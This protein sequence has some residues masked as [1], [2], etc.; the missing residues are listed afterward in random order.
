MGNRANLY[1]YVLIQVN[2]YMLQIVYDEVKHCQEEVWRGRNFKV[3][4]HQESAKISGRCKKIIFKRVQDFYIF[5]KNCSHVCSLCLF[6][7]TWFQLNHFTVL[8]V[9][10]IFRKFL[11][12]KS[13]FTAKRYHCPFLQ[14]YMNRIGIIEEQGYGWKRDSK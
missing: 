7:K 1:H 8:K 10:I 3:E 11:K 14:N 4:Q 13:S 6:R 2:K 9:L 12:L 5:T